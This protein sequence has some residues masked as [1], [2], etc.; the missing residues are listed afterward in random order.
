MVL[1]SR[2]VPRRRCERRP[3]EVGAAF[4]SSVEESH[5]AWT[6]DCDRGGGVGVGVLLWGVANW[7]LLARACASHAS[8]VL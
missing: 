7:V 2:S 3:A 5:D 6:G 1:T 8:R 4:W